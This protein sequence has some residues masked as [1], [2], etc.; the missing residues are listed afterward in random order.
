[1]RRWRVARSNLLPPSAVYLHHDRG[2]GMKSENR[3]QKKRFTCSWIYNWQAIHGQGVF[4]LEEEGVLHRLQ[5]YITYRDNTIKDLNTLLPLNKK[6]ISKLLG[7]SE[8]KCY[9][10][11]KVLQFKN[12]VREGRY[13]KG[14]KYIISPYLFWKGTEKDEEY[15]EVKKVFDLFNIEIENIFCRKNC[16]FLVAVSGKRIPIAVCTYRYIG[17]YLPTKLPITCQKYKEKCKVL[18]LVFGYWEFIEAKKK[19]N[20]WKIN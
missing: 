17:M 18:P 20:E 7:V 2:G 6:Q 4:T 16:P 3:R 1:M 9:E 8:K 19:R 15:Q 5:N 11:L 10:I 12:A 13:G 14:T